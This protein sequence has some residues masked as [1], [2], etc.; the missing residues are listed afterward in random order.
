MRFVGTLE[1]QCAYMFGAETYPPLPMAELYYT[2][3]R[4]PDPIFCEKCNEA[5]Y[6]SPKC[7]Q[8]RLRI[9][10]SSSCEA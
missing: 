1:N 7:R 10:T 2:K 3:E 4:F 9:G 8:V 6:C 5:V